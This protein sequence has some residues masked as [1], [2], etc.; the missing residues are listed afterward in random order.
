MFVVGKRL[1]EA[2]AQ[3]Q[4]RGLRPLEL[5]TKP[6]V[7]PD[8]GLALEEAEQAVREVA[9]AG[10]EFIVLKAVAIARPKDVPTEVVRLDV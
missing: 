2:A 6:R 8:E 4:F 7:H 10:Y 1:T 5:A 3:Q 9:N